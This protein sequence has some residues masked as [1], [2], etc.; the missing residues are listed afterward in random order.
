MRRGHSSTEPQQLN[1]IQDPRTSPHLVLTARLENEQVKVFV[2]C[3]AN[4]SYVSLRLGQKMTSW[5]KE[6][7]D[8]YPLAMAD[9]TPVEH[10]DGWIRQELRDVEL[11]IAGH[12]ERITLDITT[13]KYDIVLGMTWL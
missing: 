4:R 8:P 3:G 12:L 2:D 5:R 10:G 6:K 7:K 13:I 1:M 9:G 11:D